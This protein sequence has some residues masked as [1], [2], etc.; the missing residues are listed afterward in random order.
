MRILVTGGAGFIGRNLVSRLLSDGHEVTIYDN[1]SSSKKE[2][3]GAAR[4]VEGDIRDAD[5]VA[6]AMRGLLIASPRSSAAP[7]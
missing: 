3:V 5:D 6:R 1:F 4:I 7:A 2:P